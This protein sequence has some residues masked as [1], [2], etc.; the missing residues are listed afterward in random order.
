[1]KQE[2]VLIA[3]Q[4]RT[5]NSQPD[6]QLTACTAGYVRVDWKHP[7]RLKYILLECNAFL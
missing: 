6:D 4:M 5:G 3:R 1:M 7:T 2:I